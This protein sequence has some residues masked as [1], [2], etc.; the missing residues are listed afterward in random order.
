M[1][2]HPSPATRHPPLLLPPATRHPSSPSRLQA[3]D[4]LSVNQDAVRLLPRFTGRLCRVTGGMHRVAASATCGC[5]LCHPRLQARAFYKSVANLLVVEKEADYDM[6][7]VEKETVLIDDPF[8][9]VTALWEEAPSPAISRPSPAHLPPISRPSPAI[10]RYLPP[11]RTPPRHSHHSP[12]HPAPPPATPRATPRHPA[13]PP[14]TFLHL[15]LPPIHR[16]PASRT[17]ATHARGP[18]GGSASRASCTGLSTAA[19]TRA[20]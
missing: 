18:T 2:R 19:C 4:I 10:S 9:V 15:P 7:Q 1:S 13:P 6:S 5:S 12:R 3:E 16:R 20:R 14:S 11:P 17:T 8:R